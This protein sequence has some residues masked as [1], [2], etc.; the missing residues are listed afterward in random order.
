MGS[1]RLA[2]RCCKQGKHSTGCSTRDLEITLSYKGEKVQAGQALP[3]QGWL[4]R[5]QAER[6]TWIIS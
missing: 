3:Q 1:G 5:T 2:G 4:S 6:D